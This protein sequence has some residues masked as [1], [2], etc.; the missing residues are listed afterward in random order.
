[1]KTT[2]AKERAE[3]QKE[4]ERLYPA[5]DKAFAE[6][7]RAKEALGKAENKLHSI[8]REIAELH[9]ANGQRG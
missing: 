2:T 5:R 8:K 4:L 7:Q 6:V 9:K 1:M 3:R